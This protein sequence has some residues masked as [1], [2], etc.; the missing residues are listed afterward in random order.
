MTLPTKDFQR[1]LLVCPASQPSNLGPVTKTSGTGA[2][3]GRL[4]MQAEH[5]CFAR[6]TIMGVGRKGTR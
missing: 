3:A 2:F 4:E 5:F 6:N 1:V